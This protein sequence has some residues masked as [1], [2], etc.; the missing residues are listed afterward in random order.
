MSVR[1]S[2]QRAVVSVDSGQIVNPDS[3]SNQLEG[4]FTQAASW[5]LKEQVTFGP[6]GVSSVDWATYPILRFQEVPEIETVLVNRPGMPYLG[7]GEGTHG[8]VPAAIGNAVFD[9]VGVRLRRIP[10]TPE[11]VRTAMDAG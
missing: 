1:I 5:T 3:L 2:L 9:A 4:G 11:R 6:D 7:I 8:P 10:F